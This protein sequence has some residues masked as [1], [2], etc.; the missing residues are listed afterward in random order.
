M[1][2]AQQHGVSEKEGRAWGKGE[3]ANMPQGVKMDKYPASRQ[4]GPMVEDDNMSRIDAENSR[5][6]AKTRRNLSNQH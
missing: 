3:F 6:S 5:A 2:K 4:A 1:A